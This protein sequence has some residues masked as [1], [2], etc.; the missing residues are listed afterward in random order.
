MFCVFAFS[1]LSH[2]VRAAEPRHAAGRW[3]ELWQL[4]LTSHQSTH[5]LHSQQQG[6]SNRTRSH[7][8]GRLYRFSS[9]QEVPSTQLLAP[10]PETTPGVGI[11]AARNVSAAKERQGG[12]FHQKNLTPRPSSS[13]MISALCSC[14][15]ACRARSSIAS[16]KP[17]NSR[18]RKT[19][20]SAETRLT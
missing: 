19:Y 20:S 17:W 6:K 5:P 15:K 8:F 3:E 16:S 10:L 2:M 4:C 18:E 12:G 1:S 11:F 13:V 9:P 14:C 7:V